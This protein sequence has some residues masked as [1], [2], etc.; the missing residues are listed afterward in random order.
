MGTGAKL[1][2]VWDAVS[3][4]KYL[5]K[6]QLLLIF[7]CIYLLI[8]YDEKT[9]GDTAL[10]KTGGDL[11]AHG[12]DPYV[13]VGLRS[14]PIGSTVIYF[15]SLL[16][17]EGAESYFFQAVNMT[18]ILGAIYV[19][20][21]I[22]NLNRYF[23]IGSI[24]LVWTGSYREML[25]NHQ[26]NG[27]VLGCY[28]ISIYLAIFSKKKLQISYFLS[29][30]FASISLD[31][32]PHISL[33]LTLFTLILLRL[34]KIMIGIFLIT[35]SLQVILIIVTKSF[36]A[37]S[38]LQN[39]SQINR[40]SPTRWADVSNIWPLISRILGNEPAFYNLALASTLLVFLFGLYSAANNRV[41]ITLML[42]SLAP[43][44][45]IYCHLFDLVIFI[46][47]TI[48]LVL[49]YLNYLLAIPFLSLALIPREITTLS[50][51]LFLSAMLIAYI[52]YE[53]NQK[54][55]QNEKSH[56]ISRVI[57]AIILTSIIYFV[58]QVLPLDDHLYQSL[59]IMET[60]SLAVYITTIFLRNSEEN[61]ISTP[62][63]AD[64]K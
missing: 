54:T 23:Y 47:I 30:F 20:S 24:F 26:T 11:I 59:I 43:A 10:Y 52:L 29:A 9:I 25:V 4:K 45:S 42:A 33:F 16:V 21:R 48:L 64:N 39:L 63:M 22:L 56:S 6:P 28:A 5:P 17:P 15:M 49:K 53:E 58:N 8:K 18:G 50:N 62:N 7:S 36:L 35:V 27:I 60:V 41:F 32:K 19:L 46:G 51:F 57:T 38:W 34:W 1:Q 40:E 31:L 13:T 61:L 44:I 14:G 2:R 37:K 12:I 55:S 3:V